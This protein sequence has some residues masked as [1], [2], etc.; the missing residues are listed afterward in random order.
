M[1]HASTSV[2]YAVLFKKPAIFLTPDKLK[3]SWIGPRI[4]IIAQS[5]NGKLINISNNINDELH[6]DE[7]FKIDEKKYKNYLKQYLKTPKSPDLPLW[8]IINKYLKKNITQ[9]LMKYSLEKLKKNK[10]YQLLVKYKLIKSKNLSIFHYKTRDNNRLKSFIDRSSN[11]IFLEKTKKKNYYENKKTKFK[12]EKY[13]K[14]SF[15]KLKDHPLHDTNRRIVQ[16]KRF[17]KGK[18][19]MDFGCGTGSFLYNSKFFFKKGVGIELDFN[20]IKHVGKKDN[21][22]EFFRSLKKIHNFT[23]KFDT[24]FLFHVFEHLINPIETLSQ[25][26]LKLKKNGYLI[27]EV[28]HA[29]DFLLKKLKVKSFINFTLWSEHLIL[30]TKQSL[31]CFLEKAGFNKNK[32]F[33]YQRYNLSNHIGWLICNKPGGHIFFNKMFTNKEISQYNNILIK[34]RSTDNI[35]SISRL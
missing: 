19:I 24:I 32:I 28:P 22:I 8:E 9:K 23:E 12:D 21:K 15:G 17:I 10:I 11:I 26:R 1:L 13:I 4:E 30:H 34:N 29:N 3:K 16:F 31:K 14:T 27:I 7:F 33:F 6:N 5:V 25:L 35:Y 2:S 18:K 20:R